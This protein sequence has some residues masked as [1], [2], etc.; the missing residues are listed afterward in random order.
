MLFSFPIFDCIKK[1]LTTY[2]SMLIGRAVAIVCCAALLVV[3]S[4]MLVNATDN[5][6]LYLQW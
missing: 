1:K 2:K 3:S 4:I 6:F 5:P